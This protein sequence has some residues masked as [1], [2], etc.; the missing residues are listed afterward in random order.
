MIFLVAGIFSLIS[1]QN[2]ALSFFEICHLNLAVATSLNKNLFNE[3]RF[4]HMV[5]IKTN[6]IPPKVMRFIK[7]KS[8]LKVKRQIP[9]NLVKQ[10]LIYFYTVIISI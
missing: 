8:K 5:K 9:L 3:S 10:A 6:V 2:L 1:L 4:L 7:N